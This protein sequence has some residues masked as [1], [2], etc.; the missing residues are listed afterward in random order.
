MSPVQETQSMREIRLLRA[1]GEGYQVRVPP[2]DQY[3]ES[4][5]HF[6]GTTCIFS[7]EVPA[8]YITD[9]DN[10]KQHSISL[11]FTLTDCTG[12]GPI[13]ANLNATRE[14]TRLFGPFFAD[15][16]NKW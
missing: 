15:D 3:D 2:C 8:Q 6:L 5:T 7:S 1:K 14:H 10:Y 4:A 16:N 13:I 11:F 12:R 9:T